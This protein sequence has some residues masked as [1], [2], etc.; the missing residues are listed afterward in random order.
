MDLLK[1]YCQYWFVT[2]TPYGKDIEPAV[3]DKVQVMEDFKKLSN[4][5]GVDSVGWRY[6]PILINDTYTVDRHIADFEN[7]AEVL[8][9]YTKTCVISFI[10]LY[11]KVKRN[12]PEA[13][14][15]SKEDRIRIGKAFIEIAKKN[16][17]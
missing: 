3:P 4:I 14:T 8:D 5:V 12:F 9:G 13:R 16:M 7:M 10:D 15:V 17:E 6:N 11:E 2:I 1:G